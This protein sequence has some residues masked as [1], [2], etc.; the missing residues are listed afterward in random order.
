MCKHILYEST[1]NKHVAYYPFSFFFKIL[2][3]TYWFQLN[4][5]ILS[6]F[7][8]DEPYKKTLLFTK[9]GNYINNDLKEMS[10]KHLLINF[11]YSITT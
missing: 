8:L 1:Y 9:R 3:T 5:L 10:Y 6:K 2:H 4:Y 7:S 11:P